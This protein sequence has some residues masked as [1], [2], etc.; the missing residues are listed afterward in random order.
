MSGVTTQQPKK[1]PGK[2][3]LRARVESE[4]ADLRKRLEDLLRAL[5]LGPL[6]AA[7]VE[8]FA[9]EDREADAKALLASHAG[10]TEGDTRRMAE[11][12]DTAKAIVALPQV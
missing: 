2:R 6:A 4:R 3:E 9:A 10:G 1:K 12:W 7:Q 11:A 8:A 5:A